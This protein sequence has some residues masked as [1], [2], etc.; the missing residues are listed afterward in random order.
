MSKSGDLV[1]EELADME[2]SES[3]D[4]LSSSV[5]HNYNITI[6]H[7]KLLIRKTLNLLCEH[8]YM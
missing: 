7:F 2:Q 3:L 5:C 4:V 6:S 8:Q 1:N